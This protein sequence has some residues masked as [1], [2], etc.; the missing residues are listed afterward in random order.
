MDVGSLIQ[1]VRDM[2]NLNAFM[3]KERGKERELDNQVQRLVTIVAKLGISQRIAG[4]NLRMVERVVQRLLQGLQENAMCVERRV[5]VQ[6]TVDIEMQ[7]AV[8]K[9]AKVARTRA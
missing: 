5:I 8:E 4:G 9:V 1:A 2:K 6:R 7:R 3:V